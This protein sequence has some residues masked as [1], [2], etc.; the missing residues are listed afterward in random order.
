MSAR[1][2]LPNRGS[3]T[4]MKP[5]RPPINSSPTTLIHPSTSFVGTHRI[6]LGDNV[7][8]QLRTRLISTHGSMNV[9][10]DSIIG[11]RVSLGPLNSIEASSSGVEMGTEIGVGV[12]IESGVTVEAASVGNWTIIE[13]GAYVGKGAV[14]GEHCRICARVKVEEG[15]FIRSHTVVY[16]NQ[17]GERR[18]ERENDGLC[19]VQGTRKVLIEG[20][21]RSLR[22]LWTSK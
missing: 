17:H 11:E 5:T 22:S 13:A 10:R 15:D 20:Q 2:S 7:I 3:T 19:G 14:V 21:N 9:G 6:T 8:I 1:P 16:G 18:V 4:T 12:L